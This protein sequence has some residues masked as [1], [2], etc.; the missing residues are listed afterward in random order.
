VNGSFEAVPILVD[1]LR[2]QLQADV[3]TRGRL[4]R[5]RARLALLLLR[6]GAL[7]GSKIN[8]ERVRRAEVG[9]AEHGDEEVVVEINRGTIVYTHTPGT[10][11]VRLVF[12]MNPTVEFAVRRVARRRTQVLRDQRRMQTLLNRLA[13]QRREGRTQP[14]PRRVRVHSG[15]RGDPP[16]DGSEDDDPHDAARRALRPAGAHP[17]RVAAQRSAR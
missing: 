15:S 11:L 13:R 14:R 16:A 3:A 4:P 2:E 12:T 10:G 9:V 17:D 6:A 7:R 1:R 5:D 8:G